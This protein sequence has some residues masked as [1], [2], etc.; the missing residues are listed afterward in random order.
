M[1]AE[2][3]CISSRQLERMIFVQEVGSV[4]VIWPYWCDKLAGKSALLLYVSVMALGVLYGM[5]CLWWAENKSTGI[6]RIKESIWYRKGLGFACGI[7][8]IF[9]AI[10]LLLFGTYV[11]QDALLPEVKWWIIMLLFALAG[12]FFAYQGLEAM[13][14]VCECI[15]VVWLLIFG[16][17]ALLLLVGVSSQPGGGIDWSKETNLFTVL[18]LVML[19]TPF[20]ILLFA[21]NHLGNDIR[22]RNML[23]NMLLLF[24]VGFCVY[25]ATLR[26]EMTGSIWDGVSERIQTLEYMKML[27]VKD[28]DIWGLEAI[29]VLAVLGSMLIQFAAFLQVGGYLF[30]KKSSRKRSICLLVMTVWVIGLLSVGKG[31]LIPLENGVTQ[32][33]ELEERSF[34]RGMYI[35]HLQDEYQILFD[36][37]N[38]ND[39]TQNEIYREKEYIARGETIEACIKD[40]EEM[41]GYFMDF[42]HL[43][44]VL[45]YKDMEQ[46][47]VKEAVAQLSMSQGISPQTALYQ[48]SRTIGK[49]EVYVKERQD[50]L[51]E[52][53]GRRM[54]KNPLHLYQ[55]GSAGYETLPLLQF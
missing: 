27:K 9:L 38:L 10:V 13:A 24:G 37:A 30:A 39:Y 42:T 54:K 11:V 36:F 7:K 55:Y 41:T 17:M 49:M 3:D 53:I 23:W 14:R 18:L 21:D 28:W 32:K 15:Y 52:M 2:N 43:Q 35:C 46:R 33:V 12:G 45:F 31:W 50:S 1:F 4:C 40:Y 20:D 26:S 51:G 34:V 16:C 6:C 19:A 8:Y 48:V 5:L 44:A 22:K 25:L 29:W 47:K